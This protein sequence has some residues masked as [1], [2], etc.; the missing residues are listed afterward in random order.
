MRKFYAHQ[1]VDDNDARVFWQGRGAYG[2]VVKAK[3]KMDGGT[4]AGNVT[5]TH[6]MANSY[7]E[8]FGLECSQ[9][10]QTSGW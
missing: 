7:R 4:Y 6:L 3:H 1:V 8:L 9:E 2:S 5:S 10:D